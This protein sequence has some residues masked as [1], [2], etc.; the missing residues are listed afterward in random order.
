MNFLK[1]KQFIVSIV[2]LAVFLGT[3]IREAQT[4]Y[5]YQKNIWITSGKVSNGPHTDFPLLFSVTD[6]DLRTVANGGHVENTNGYDIVFRDST[7][8]FLD[9]EVEHYDGA[10]GKLIAWVRVPSIDNGTDLYIQYGDASISSSQQNKTGVW[11]TNYGGVWH[12]AETSSPYNDSTSNGNNSASGTYPTQDDGKIGKG[13]TFNGAQNIYVPATSSIELTTDGT[14][15]LWFNPSNVSVLYELIEKGGSGGYT[16]FF[17]YQ[18]SQWPGMWWGPQDKTVPTWANVANPSMSI[19][20]WYKLDGVTNN[21]INKLYINGSQFVSSGTSTWTYSNTGSLQIGNGEDGYAHGTIDELRVSKVVR[22]AGWIQTEYNNQSNPS[23]FYSLGSERTVIT[24]ASFSAR[25]DGATV[26]VEWVT[27][28]EIDNLGFNLYRSVHNGPLAKVNTELI[29]GLLSSISGRS[30]AYRDTGA[31]AGSPVCYT[32]EDIDL[33]ETRTTHGPVCVYRLDATTIQQG[34]ASGQPPSPGPVETR[35]VTSVT[36]TSLTAR[37]DGHGVLIEWTTGQEVANLGFHVWRQEQGQRTRLTRGLLAGAALKTGAASLA[38]G[39]AYRFYDGN[40]GSAY[41]I[42]DI[43]LKGARALHGPVVPTLSATPLPTGSSHSLR[44]VTG[45]NP[46][47]LAQEALSARI[48]SRRSPAGRGEPFPAQLMSPQE[49]QRALARSQ[50]VK[51]FIRDDG[52]Y[53]ISLADL[54][55]LGLAVGNPRILQ[56]YLGGKEEPLSVQNGAIEFYGAGIDTPYTDTNVYWLIAGLRPGKRIQRAAGVRTQGTQTSFPFPV[57]LTER[58][59]YFAALQNG[60]AENFFGSVIA[61]DP[62]EKE[63]RVTHRAAG[64]ALLEVT[65][66]GVTVQPHEVTI[67]LNG[68]VVG[69]ISF[70]GQHKGTASFSIPEAGLEEGT[71]TV[72]FTA[73]GE[74]DVSML[75]TIR[76]TYPRTYTVEQ[77]RLTFTAQGGNQVTVRG[78]S[79]TPVRVLDITDPESVQELTGKI[80][81]DGPGYAVEIGIPGA[82]ERTLIASTERASLAPAALAANEPASWYTSAGA[83]L[84]MVSHHDFTA[85]LSPLK[86]LRERTGLSV[87]VVDIEDVY[88]EFSF[89]IQ[90][91]YA[92]KD[93]MTRARSWRRPPQYL[94]VVGDASFDPKNYLGLGSF[95]FVPTKLVDATYLE[96][97]S[98]DWFVDGNNDLVPD[99]PVGRLP[100]RTRD[101]AALVVAKLTGYQGGRTALFL[102]DETTEAFDFATASEQAKALLPPSVSAQTFYRGTLPDSQLKT[103]F[104]AAFDQG[105][106]LVNYVGHGSEGIWR[107]DIFTSP[108]AETLSNGYRLPVVVAMTCLNGLFQ[109]VYAESLAEALLLAPTGGAIAVFASSGLTEPYPQSLMN[110]AFIRAL[111]SGQQLTLGKAILQAKQATT[112]PDVR[113]TWVLIGDPATRLK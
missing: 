32:L 90:T 34:S 46:K 111:F 95:D 86:A 59:I 94:L 103:D 10:T 41:I 106:L 65:L 85:S 2:A 26:T 74:L 104:L 77:D 55:S 14:V 68:Q 67:A 7:G 4:F 47:A 107:G 108:D 19:G 20:Q 3:S 109:D 101:A 69:S 83:D 6:P 97:A 23:G 88:D 72:R 53:R 100:V 61:A 22:S 99:I 17:D 40:P 93:F 39:H 8:A 28:T 52:W 48:G 15:S 1:S 31:P 45:Y 35:S 27:K 91:P 78:F 16:Y 96:T 79:A 21:G 70:S 76:L 54:A 18:G 62:V 66:Q 113:K 37:T 102:A 64:E 56:L 25:A 112:D 98:D 44:A 13:Q 63:L 87:V 73:S 82:G 110:R 24:L 42:E 58:S 51:L 49:T 81:P 36:L 12:L 9:Y 75:D 33:R 105:P 38:A 60:D 57:T 30:Y 50:A 80:K 43:D 5:A 92:L 89:G 71:N 29:P 84:V 11:G